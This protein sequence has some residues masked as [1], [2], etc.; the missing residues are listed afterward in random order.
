M[1]DRPLFSDAN[2]YD[3]IE[4]QKQTVKTEIY[5]LDKNYLLNTSESDLINWLANKL[6]LDVP[7]IL[8]TEIHVSA[9]GETKIDVSHDQMRWIEDRSQP[10]F[11]Q[12][13][14]TTI[15]IPFSGDA[16]FFKIRPSSFT[17]V[18]P[19]ANIIGNELL[20]T[21][22]QVEANGENIKRE[23][24]NTLNQIKKYLGWLKENVSHFN[25]T[26]ESTIRNYISE[27]KN[28][29]LVGAGM[30]ESLGL[31][32]KKREDAPTTYAVPVSR[33]R[34]RIEKPTATTSHFK[35]EPVLAPEEYEHILSIMKNMVLVMEKSPQAF[36]SMDEEAL[37]THFLVQL[38]GQ[39][40]GQATGETF[41]YHG[42]T[43]I[44][45]S[46]EGRN[47]FIAECKFWKGE[48]KYLE[49]IDQLLDRYLSWRDTKTA[50]LIFNR[51]QNFTDVLEVIESATPNH[52]C[53]KRFLGK[54]DDSTFRYIFH[55]T[56]DINREIEL[57]IMG[58]NI[59]TK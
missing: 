32:I 21:Y 25:S 59:P 51:N 5:S 7:E 1:K 11:V 35:P 17:T 26:L 4:T 16:G 15:A 12:G 34:A 14:Q 9:H 29:I 40:E 56:E 57:T 20:L 8:E 10:L 31:P 42:K 18:L 49:T 58:F 54:S 43:D 23:Y 47:V 48:K 52:R 41:N 33:R 2:I 50:I 38:N 13:T 19:R 45:I 37:R 36:E 46:Y 6:Y 53:F 3:V 55:Q 24:T 30:V 44:L 27:R 39:Y 22:K 28:R